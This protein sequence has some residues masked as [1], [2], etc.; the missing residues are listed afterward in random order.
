MSEHDQSTCVPCGHASEHGW[1]G[2]KSGTHCRQCHRTWT[3]AKQAHCVTCC[4]H[5]S[6]P[7]TFDFHFGKEG[8]HRDPMQKNREFRQA[9]DGT[10]FKAQ[11][12]EERWYQ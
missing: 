1:F 12:S 8:E 7:S 4:R 5:F 6:S 11:S 3:G 10:W 9:D 2:L